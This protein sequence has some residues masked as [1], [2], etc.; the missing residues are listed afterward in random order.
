MKNIQFSIAVHILTGLA[1]YRGRVPSRIVSNSVNTTPSFVR[2]VLAK[3]S[4]AGLVQTSTGKSGFCLLAKD[5][6]RVTLLDIY[7]A[8]DCPKVIAIHD[9]PALESCVVS[10]RIKPSLRRIQDAVERSIR[11][12]L[13]GITLASVLGE[14]EG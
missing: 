11:K 3:L 12:S 8:L 10:R 4:K 5:P 1:Q 2:R 7:R 13:A 14:V 9:Y 6:R